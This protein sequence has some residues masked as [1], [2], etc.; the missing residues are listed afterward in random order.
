[1][2]L[3]WVSEWGRSMRERERER[4]FQEGERKFV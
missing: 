3:K 1:M 2:G 4:K